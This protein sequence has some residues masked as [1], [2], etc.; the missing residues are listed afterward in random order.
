[1]EAHGLGYVKDGILGA[2]QQVAGVGDSGAVEKIQGG[3]VHDIPEH[4]AEM[5]R[6]PAAQIRQMTDGELLAVIVFDKVKGRSDDQSVA[7]LLSRLSLA[8]VFG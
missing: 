7:L 8:A 3:N 5:G 2:L 4:S 6:A 1:M